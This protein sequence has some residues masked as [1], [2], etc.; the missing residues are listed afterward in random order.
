M[1]IEIELKIRISIDYKFTIV[2]FK[3]NSNSILYQKVLRKNR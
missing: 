2:F 3:N 1:K